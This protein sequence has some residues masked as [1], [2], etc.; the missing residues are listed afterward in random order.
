MSAL[1]SKVS[2]L[3]A[4][5][6]V[7][8]MKD[9]YGDVI[10]VGKAASLKNRVK[11]YFQNTEKKG[12]KVTALVHN[13]EDL[14]YIVTDSEVEALILESNLIK[15]YRPKYN[16]S[17][18][19]D[20]HYPYIKID[21]TEDFPRVEKVRKINKDKARYFGP[22]PS[23]G[24]VNET[25][26]LVHKIFSLRRC[27]GKLE[28]KDRP[29]LNFQIKRC[30]APC[31]HN[32]TSTDYHKMIEEVLLFL[33][34]KSSHLVK[35][36][37][38]EMKEQA[39][40]LNFE[41]AAEL[42]DQL[43]ALKSVTEKQK[44]I[45]S[46]LTDRDILAVADGGN[47][48][49]IQVFSIRGGKLLGRDSFRLEN[50]GGSTS[51]ELLI[52]FITQFYENAP[53]VPGEILVPED[54]FDQQV[55]LEFLQKKR[56]SKVSLKVPQKGEKKELLILAK[57]NA[58]LQLE[59]YESQGGV[60]KHR[61]EKGVVELAKELKFG[62][63]PWRMECYDI[64]NIQG[65]YSVGSMVVFEGG[66]PAKDKYRK[67][68][69][70]TVEGPNDFASMAEVL[71]RRLKKYA[72]GDEKFSPLP[73]LIVIDG[74][75]G[76]LSAANKIVKEQGYEHV[77]IIGLAKKMEE[78]FFPEQSEPVILPRNSEGLYLLQRIRDEAHRFAITY[79]R[80]LRKNETF[81]SELDSIE[82]VGP[83]RRNSLLKVFNS[84]E[85]ISTK[86]VGEIAAV[87]GIPW[88]VAENVYRYFRK[89]R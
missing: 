63:L 68:K 65:E 20:K 11:S 57:K 60:E 19:D 35:K 24:A 83:N 66:K 89:K 53:I 74:G 62:E 3:P 70:R 15:K 46:D 64:S 78:V 61:G 58:R 29:C 76:Q 84:V 50:T 80:T 27:K 52:A 36:V 2:Q 34:G 39:A 48:A 88:Q 75:K 26:Q 44:I 73:H 10:Y 51:K 45:F 25:L 12:A 47:L 30:H 67:F 9:K 86:D 72:E 77:H 7:Y 49:C 79:H 22:Y 13:I 87:P 8:F 33:E 32:I 14:D 85:E 40:N 81:T 56:G 43:K 71:T 6:G 31:Q 55:L 5:P 21:V 37:E 41:K 23:A 38:A 16:I 1:N 42:R 69:I 59:Q 28:H 4:S 54:L 82:G 17:L 18:K